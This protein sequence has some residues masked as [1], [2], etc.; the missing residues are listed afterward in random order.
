VQG[1]SI[2]ATFKSSNKSARNYRR[3]R[4]YRRES[5]NCSGTNETEKVEEPEP[6]PY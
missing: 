4:W 2:T 3:W 5:I 1:S 6:K